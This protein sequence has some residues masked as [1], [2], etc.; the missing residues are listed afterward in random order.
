M[1]GPKREGI[2]KRALVTGGSRGIGFQIA[3]I[4]AIHGVDVCISG[5]NRQRLEAAK[6]RIAE[7]A[8]SPPVFSLINKA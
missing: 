2:V 1:G 3:K 5:T 7:E 6:S 8:S 4:L